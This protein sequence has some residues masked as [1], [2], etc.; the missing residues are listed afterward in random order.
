VTLSTISAI[1]GAL[2]G[3]ID[4]V[5]GIRVAPTVPPEQLAGSGVFAILTPASGRYHMIAPGR[6]EVNHTFH[7]MI[8]TP[9][10][11]LRTDYARVLALGDT[12]P[13]ALEG[14]GTISGMI[15][16]IDEER[17][18]FGRTEWGGQDYFGYVWELDVRATGT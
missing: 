9:Y 3:I 12:I 8:A 7:L 5:S 11:N 4:D 10:A 17:Y 13:K 2:Q 1:V 16:Q 6:Y 15:V 14:A 18:T